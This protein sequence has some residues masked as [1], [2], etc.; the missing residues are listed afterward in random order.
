MPEIEALPIAMR[1]CFYYVPFLILSFFDYAQ[2]K[3]TPIVL[4]FTENQKP[5]LFTQ[6]TIS[7]VLISWTATGP[8]NSIHV[9]R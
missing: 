8:K 5:I 3:A 1:F 4:L 2:K 7:A 9:A 6:F